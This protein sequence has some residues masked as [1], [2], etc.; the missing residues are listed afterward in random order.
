MEYTLFLPARK[1][2]VLCSQK[3]HHSSGKKSLPRIVTD[4]FNISYDTLIFKIPIYIMGMMFKY[5]VKEKSKFIP[6][7]SEFD[8]LK[9]NLGGSH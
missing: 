6:S 7:G 2:L 8:S 5:S 1:S 4:H 9:R 3:S